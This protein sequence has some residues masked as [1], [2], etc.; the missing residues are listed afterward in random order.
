MSSKVYQRRI[1]STSL[2]VTAIPPNPLTPPQPNS[3]IESKKE[4]HLAKGQNSQNI[5]NQQLPYFITNMP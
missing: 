4:G 5:K 3:S 1:P 2:L